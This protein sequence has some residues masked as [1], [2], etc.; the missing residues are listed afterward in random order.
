MSHVTDDG[1]GSLL[2]RAIGLCALFPLVGSFFPFLGE[3]ETKG[4]TFRGTKSPWH[5]GL[6]LSIWTFPHNPTMENTGSSDTPML[7]LQLVSGEAEGGPD[8]LPDP[9]FPICVCATCPSYNPALLHLPL[10]VAGG[11]RIPP[12]SLSIQ[13]ESFLLCKLKSKFGNYIL[14]AT[15]CFPSIRYPIQNLSLSG[16]EQN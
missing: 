15:I 16:Q 10:V 1:L 12:W 4:E 7:E 11:C 5:A 6:H 13:L 14:L 8:T 3:L 9:S 2:C